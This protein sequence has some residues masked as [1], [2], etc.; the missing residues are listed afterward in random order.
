MEFASH[1]SRKEPANGHVSMQYE[2]T[3][4]SKKHGRKNRTKSKPKEYSQHDLNNFTSKPETKILYL[5][6]LAEFE[7]WIVWQRKILLCGLTKKCTR[8]FLQTLSTVFE[9]VLHINL[10]RSSMSPIRL[11][12]HF[13][14]L[15]EREINVQQGPISPFETDES[16]SRKAINHKEEIPKF[17]IPRE[18]TNHRSD[19]EEH[20]LPLIT[21]PAKNRKTYCTDPSQEEQDCNNNHV[22][23]SA[24]SKSSRRTINF[25]PN[26]MTSRTN[27]LG[28][29]CSVRTVVN[30]GTVNSRYS[31]KDF[32]NRKWWTVPSS[33]AYKLAVPKGKL[34]MQNFRKSLETTYMVPNKFVL[35]FFDFF[36]FLVCC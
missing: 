31:T 14:I 25:F 19:N 3:K 10:I 35:N 27:Q 18:I 13:K 1:V 7:N 28:K 24:S 16:F 2:G 11:K 8:P 17:S 29:I 33:D 4:K 23:Q 34:L 21:S 32:K 36:I 12:N 20:F 9:P 30:D 6:V 26:I 5:K 15:P 22:H